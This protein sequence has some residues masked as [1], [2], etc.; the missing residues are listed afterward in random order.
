MKAKKEKKAF[1]QQKSETEHT[2]SE[3]NNQSSKVCKETT[4]NQKSVNSIAFVLR[5]S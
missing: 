2:N 4:S 3:N 5:A 1:P